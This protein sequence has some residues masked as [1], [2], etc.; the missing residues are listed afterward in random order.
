MV[1]QIQP[2]AQEILELPWARYVTCRAWVPKLFREPHFNQLST[3]D[4]PWVFGHFCTV[5]GK[6]LWISK[7]WTET[8]NL[9]CPMDMVYQIWNQGTCAH[10]SN[11]PLLA[12][13]TAAFTGCYAAPGK[14]HTQLLLKL[15]CVTWPIWDPSSPRD[16][17]NSPGTLAHRDLQF[18]F[19]TAV[20]RCT[21]RPSGGQYRRGKFRYLLS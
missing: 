18:S 5:L 10:R 4:F 1:V 21:Q 16:A 6:G 20:R 12:C 15:S 19:N 17:D 9:G 7:C 14:A 13:L 3:T 8:V 11:H 2:L